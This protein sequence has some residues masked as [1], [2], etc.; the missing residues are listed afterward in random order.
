MLFRLLSNIKH[1]NINKN[2]IFLIGI[3][4]SKYTD[5][6]FIIFNNN[7][8]QIVNKNFKFLDICTVQ[9]MY[10]YQDKIQFCLLNEYLN[11]LYNSFKKVT[12]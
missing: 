9:Q 10:K 7:E 5:D 4:K 2:T 12:N 6:K 8:F 11:F 3:L 1:T